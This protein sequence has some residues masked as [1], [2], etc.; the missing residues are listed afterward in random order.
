M[1]GFRSLT[2]ASQT[3][4]QYASG[5]SMVDDS[6]DTRP[7]IERVGLYNQFG[8]QCRFR[9]SPSHKC[10]LSRGGKG[11]VERK[12]RDALASRWQHTARPRVGCRITVHTF[13]DSPYCA[14]SDEGRYDD[15]RTRVHH[16]IVPNPYSQPAACP[17]RQGRRGRGGVAVVVEEGGHYL[18]LR[19]LGFWYSGHRVGSALIEEED[20]V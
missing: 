12:N 16:S 20:T 5:K 8:M 19:G 1:E 9:T 6:F 14:S 2:S 3:Y 10:N 7:C 11:Q 13:D 15:A 4:V 18:R 17:S